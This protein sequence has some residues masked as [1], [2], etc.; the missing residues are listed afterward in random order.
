MRE[1]QLQDLTQ[2]ELEEKFDSVE[3]PW[4]RKYGREL[5]EI[6]QDENF[7]EREKSAKLIEKIDELG[8]KPYDPPEPLPPIDSE[9][10][11]L[12]CWMAVSPY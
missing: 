9:Q 2:Q 8:L 11:K 12:V 4:V 10:I 3:A 1:H 6:Y 7:S 5:R